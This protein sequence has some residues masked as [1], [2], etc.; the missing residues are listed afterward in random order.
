MRCDDVRNSNRKETRESTLRAARR[1]GEE[2]PATVDPVCQYY[3]KA[4]SS[5]REPGTPAGLASRSVSYELSVG[6]TV[7]V[8]SNRQHR[9]QN[10]GNNA[11]RNDDGRRRTTMPLS[12][13]PITDQSALISVQLSPPTKQTLNESSM[14]VNMVGKYRLG[15]EQEGDTRSGDECC[16]CWR[17]LMRNHH[18]SVR[19]TRGHQQQRSSAELPPARFVL[20]F[21]AR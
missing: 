4:R 9:T 2:W 15:G 17:R 12:A 3:E 8:R 21:D 10:E 5:S 19:R 1:E 18:K 14:M 11:T 20:A 13:D 16:C 6:S 7:P